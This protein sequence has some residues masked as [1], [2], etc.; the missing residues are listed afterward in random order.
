MA[1]N[2]MPYPVCCNCRLLQ[3]SPATEYLSFKCMADETPIITP[4]AYCPN[5]F[6]EEE[7]TCSK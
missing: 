3:G 4:P 5:K 2:K 7:T 6:K 1:Q